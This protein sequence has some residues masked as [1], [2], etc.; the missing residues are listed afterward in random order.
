MCWLRSILRSHYQLTISKCRRHARFNVS[1]HAQIDTHEL[2]FYLLRTVFQFSLFRWYVLEIISYLFFFLSFFF[3]SRSLSFSLSRLEGIQYKTCFSFIFWAAHTHA[4]C[5]CTTQLHNRSIK[6][7]ASPT[8]PP[9]YALLYVTRISNLRFKRI[10]VQIVLLNGKFGCKSNITILE[11]WKSKRLKLKSQR[12]N[13]FIFPL[14]IRFFY[15]LIFVW[16]FGIR[17]QLNAIKIWKVVNR[18]R[19]K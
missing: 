16:R 19:A 8:A 2:R 1:V 4:C 18:M 9:S 7:I 10:A 5:Q 11:I 15:S 6:T 14:L 12:T 17:S 3:F 13:S